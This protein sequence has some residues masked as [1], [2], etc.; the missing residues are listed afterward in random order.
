MMTVRRREKDAL[1]M[2]IRR[3]EKDA[4]MM[5]IRNCT[6]ARSKHRACRADGGRG[7]GRRRTA[8]NAKVLR[9]G[10]LFELLYSGHRNLRA[11]AYDA[12]RG[13]GGSGRR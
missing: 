4:L 10:L 1:M 8:G 11:P 3:R 2:T 13:R 7:A 9:A 6:R 12:F 5:T